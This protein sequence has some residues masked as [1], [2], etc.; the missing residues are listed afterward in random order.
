VTQL[1]GLFKK[2]IGWKDVE[3]M[4]IVS[5]TEVYKK[6]PLTMPA[7]SVRDVIQR[8]IQVGNLK[9]SPPQH[10]AI[11]M[12]CIT[13]QL[14]SDLKDIL[15][16]SIGKD[17]SLNQHGVIELIDAMPRFGIFFRDTPTMAD[18]QKSIFGN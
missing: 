16:K 15:K 6:F 5:A 4:F 2:E 9:L 12:A 11:E 13:M 18:L 3:F 10:N 17:G 8:T 1:F 14:S 7:D